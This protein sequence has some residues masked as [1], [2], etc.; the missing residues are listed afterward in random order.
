MEDREIIRWADLLN[1]PSKPKSLI[2]EDLLNNSKTDK[3]SVEDVVTCRRA[4]ELIKEGKVND[5]S[6]DPARYALRRGLPPSDE[7]DGD[8]QV[9]IE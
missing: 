4:L 6:V 8:E 9:E 2:I 5:N 1:D 7:L 3:M